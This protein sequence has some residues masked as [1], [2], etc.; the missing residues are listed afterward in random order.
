M[1]PRVW[2]LLCYNLSHFHYRR[3]S[4]GPTLLGWLE[5]RELKANH[6][7]EKLSDLW[8]VVI[9][10]R[11][12]GE[13]H[14]WGRVGRT[15]CAGAGSGDAAVVGVESLASFFQQLRNAKDVSRQGMMSSE[16]CWYYLQLTQTRRIFP[17]GKCSS[18]TFLGIFSQEILPKPTVWGCINR[19]VKPWCN[20][21]QAGLVLRLCDRTQ[22]CSTGAMW[23]QGKDG[24]W[25][26]EFHMSWLPKNLSMSLL[27]VV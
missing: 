1:W 18:F 8:P 11:I 7:W 25:I 26:P 17:A 23:A 15:S 4:G 22:R 10:L 16:G 20:E 27:L 12:A 3:F 21:L 14:K 9:L 2:T 6:P 19:K 5:N 13:F 24:W